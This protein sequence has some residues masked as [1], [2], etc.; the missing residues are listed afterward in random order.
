MCVHGPWK[1][2]DVVGFC[3]KV[4]CLA[5]RRSVVHTHVR[6]T[7]FIV[8]AE[9]SVAVAGALADA[10]RAF[11]AISSTAASI[12]FS[13]AFVTE[14]YLALIIVQHDRRARKRAHIVAAN[15]NLRLESHLQTRTRDLKVK[16][17]RRSALWRGPTFA[18][19]SRGGCRRHGCPRN[20]K[21][22]LRRKLAVANIQLGNARW[23]FQLRL[24]LL[25]LV[26]LRLV[27]LRLLSRGQRICRVIW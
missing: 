7:R 12:T 11:L 23:T 18:N 15:N 27:L 14:V 26:L 10:N 3:E 8:K 4:M 1:L 25:R 16:H 17:I 24:V 21:N 9:L 22:Q 5:R 20:W 13:S 19:V 2:P 6:R